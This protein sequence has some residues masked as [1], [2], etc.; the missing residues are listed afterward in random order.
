MRKGFLFCLAF[1]IMLHISAQPPLY[2]K[3][4][5]V[6]RDGSGTILAGKMVGFQ[7]SVLKNNASGPVVYREIHQK[8]T[9]AF[10]LVD[11]EIGN[12]TPGFGEFSKIDWGSDKFFIKIE[13]DPAGGLSFK[14]WEPPSC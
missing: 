2:F 3:Y 1:L 10:G 12:G 11:L 6:A 7:I 14:R 5:A 8:S 4:Q 13:M 9:N